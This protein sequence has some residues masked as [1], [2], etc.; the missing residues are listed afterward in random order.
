MESE[1]KNYKKS[2]TQLMICFSGV[3]EITNKDKRTL[4]ND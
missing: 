1:K 3:Q 4:V 2:A